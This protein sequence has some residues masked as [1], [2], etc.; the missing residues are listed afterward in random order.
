MVVQINQKIENQIRY[1]CS[2][3]TDQEWAGVIFYKIFNNEK[4]KTIWFEVVGFLPQIYGKS[5]SVET[6][7]EVEKIQ[8]GYR[9]KHFK[10][11][12]VYTGRIHSHNTMNVFFSDTDNTHLEQM[13][14][15][16]QPILSI[17]TNNDGDYFGKFA[18]YTKDFLNNDI[19]HST[20]ITVKIVY[21]IEIEFK[22]TIKKLVNTYKNNI[23][24]N[25][26]K[27]KYDLWDE[28]YPNNFFKQNEIIP[29]KKIKTPIVEFCKYYNYNA[30]NL[31][32]E[33]LDTLP[34]TSERFKFSL[35][36][37]DQLEESILAYIHKNTK[38][39]KKYVNDLGISK[40]DKTYFN[41]YININYN[42]QNKI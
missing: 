14:G 13:V 5:G 10:G 2:K 35:D 31:N 42:G 20:E 40:K 21:E 27:N 15:N 23:K 38:L 24:Q 32:Y 9:I 18:Y 16:N 33:I 36:E 6:N 1:T 17:V 7:P 29:S 28:I 19:V 12:K 11:Q 34:I 39:L 41:N 37:Q 30:Y 8:N 3:L 22:N 25:L 26:N 4:K